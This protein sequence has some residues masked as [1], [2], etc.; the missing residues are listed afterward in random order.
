MRKIWCVFT[1]LTLAIGGRKNRC[2]FT[3]PGRVY[4]TTEE[5]AVL[6]DAYTARG[7]RVVHMIMSDNGTPNDLFDDWLVD[8]EYLD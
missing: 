1:I 8:W 6:Y 2:D 7:G 3:N 4:V 5:G